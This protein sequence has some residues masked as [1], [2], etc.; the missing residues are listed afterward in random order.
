M[1]SDAS[2]D[3][4]RE[5]TRERPIDDYQRIRKASRWVARDTAD[6]MKRTAA[7]RAGLAEQYERLANTSPARTARHYRERARELR[8]LSERAERFA[9][10]ERDVAERHEPPR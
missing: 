8:T 7:V 10:R 3:D 4:T 5:D 6:A 1:A 2:G 9:R